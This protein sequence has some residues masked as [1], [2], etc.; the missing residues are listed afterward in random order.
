MSLASLAGLSSGVVFLYAEFPITSATL[1]PSATETDVKGGGVAA[2]T[3][4]AGSTPA[5]S[6]DAEVWIGFSTFMLSF[7][8][9]TAAAFA[10]LPT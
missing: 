10:S 7:G 9:T 3:G 8:G 6:G 1:L 4:F 5:T 2:A